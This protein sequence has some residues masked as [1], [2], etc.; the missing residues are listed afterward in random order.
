MKKSPSEIAREI[1]REAGGVCLVPL[2]G[3]FGLTSHEKTFCDCEVEKMLEKA[4][5]AERARSAGPAVL[6]RRT[7][8]TPFELGIKP[9][10]S[11]IRVRLRGR[12][13]SR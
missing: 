5:E 10:D 4:I 11:N 12:G 2:P 9:Q 3:K 13:E 1:V 7:S 6:A 8:T